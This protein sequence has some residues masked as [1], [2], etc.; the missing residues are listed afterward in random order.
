MGRRGVAD[1]V[2]NVDRRRAGP[3]GRLD[4]FAQKIELGARGVLGRELDVVAVAG[5]PADAV[6][7]PIDDFLFVHLELELAMDGAGGQ[8]DVDARGIA[9][10]QG[11]PGAIDVFVVAAGQPADDRAVNV[12]GDLADRF[13][14]A[15]RGDRETGLDDVDAQVDQGLGDLQLLGQ[16]HAR[17]GRL[18][19]VAERGV[20]NPT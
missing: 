3:D 2:G 17:A 6:H 7:G 15:R 18:L 20:E 1:R 13:E 4:D 14:V 16:V 9:V 12:L 19:A 10:A 5:R 8:K 11:F